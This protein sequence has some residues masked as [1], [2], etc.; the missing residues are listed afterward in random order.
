MK[1]G[2]FYEH[3]LPR[4]WAEDSELTLFQDALDQV[5]LADR[6]GLDHAW[7]VEHHFLEE[8]SHSSAPEVFLAACSQ[9]TRRIR[10]GHGIVLMPPGYNQ[11][12][13]VAERIATLDL[14]SRGRVD[15]GTGESASRAELEG[16]GV[17]PAARRAMWREAVEQVANMMVMEPYPGYRGK[18]FSMPV[19]NVL[20]KPTQKPHPPM[21]LACSSRDSILRAARAGLG[22]LV[23]G[24]V[25]PEQ[26]QSWVKEYYD[27]IRSD[28]CVPLGHSVNANIACVCAMSV[29]PDADE[30]MRRGQ[31]GFKF[32]GYSIGHHAVYGVHRPSLTNI[33]DQ[34][35]EVK[36]TLP[37]NP[38]EGG[39]GT[40]R[41]VLSHLTRYAQTGMDQ[42][43]MMLQSGRNRHDHICESLELFAREVMPALKENE[44]KRVAKKNAEL[45]PFIEAALKRKE[46]LPPVAPQDIPGIKA[47][48]I[49]IQEK[50]GQDYA[51]SGVYADP[52]R[53]GGISIPAHDPRR[54]DKAAS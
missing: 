6:L 3:Q 48:G 18:Y 7:E 39:I 44:D 4:P 49:R 35:V 45:E 40:P 23:F 27:I 50:T 19:R 31:E 43:I 22:A 13:R 5:E 17:P 21:W 30:A 8:Y 33:W 42:M 54:S 26:A 36:D 11:P 37:Y 46:R 41:Q 9:R 20:P 25:T 28:Q 38:G 24:F 52:T 1:F 10:L 51:A 14:V 15:W 32:F 53:G 34:F 16:Y 47:T 12:A 2:I 29:H